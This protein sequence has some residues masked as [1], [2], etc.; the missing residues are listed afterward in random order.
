[1]V[2]SMNSLKTYQLFSEVYDSIMEHIDFSQWANFILKAC[3]KEKPLSILD[4][5]CGTGSLLSK[6]ISIP[7]RVGIDQSQEMLKIAK[8]LHP[9]IDFRKGN[10]QDFKVEGQFDLVIC[11]HDTLNYLL[12]EF[13]LED[14]LKS[15]NRALK[16]D[17]IY[18]FDLSSEYNLTK[19]FDNQ[20][21]HH[22]E[23]DLSLIWE[24]H[25][26]RKTKEITS[27]LSFK[28]ET[29]S[30]SEFFTEVHVQKYYSN[31]QMEALLKKTGFDLLKIGND[32]KKWTATPNCS[33]INFLA[34]KKTSV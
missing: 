13:D 16:Q 31:L 14:H 8:K 22:E 26:D 10:L 2:F 4:L 33:L 6:M 29:E 5:G 34:R 27:R 19:N 9:G 30:G 1:M 12:S 15:V 7:R 23:G 32:Y 20:T 21:I 25:Y 18:I 28:K 24:N 3:E 11:T 17:G